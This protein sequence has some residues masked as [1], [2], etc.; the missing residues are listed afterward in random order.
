MG[1]GSLR[2]PRPLPPSSS[3]RRARQWAETL[4][5][6]LVMVMVMVTEFAHCAEYMLSGAQLPMYTSGASTSR[7]SKRSA[8][9]PR[10]GVADNLKSRKEREKRLG[11][12]RHEGE[13]APA[14]RCPLLPLQDT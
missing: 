13:A 6:K 7:K 3:N 10:S 14:S 1:S 12:G 8:R 5:K 2:R 4:W 11:R 9:Q